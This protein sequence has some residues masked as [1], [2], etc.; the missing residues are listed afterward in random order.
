MHTILHYM[1][2]SKQNCR[3]FHSQDSSYK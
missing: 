2:E 1:S 3:H